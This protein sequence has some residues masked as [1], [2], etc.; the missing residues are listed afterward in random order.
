M[1]VDVALRH[2]NMW[3]GLSSL[4]FVKQ[5]SALFEE[6]SIVNLIMHICIFIYIYI[7]YHSS[8]L[9]YLFVKYA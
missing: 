9:S 1:E 3:E 5:V 4:W 7:T 8:T 6:K 2:P